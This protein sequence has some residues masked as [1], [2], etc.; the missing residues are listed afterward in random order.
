[1]DDG[2]RIVWIGQPDARRAAL[3]PTSLLAVL[4]GVFMVAAVALM[5]S[6]VMPPTDDD[7]LSQQP[8]N[9]AVLVPFGLFGLL[10]M[11]RP[12]AQ[13]R[14]ARRTGYVVTDRRIAMV[15]VGRL[16]SVLSIPTSDL[17]TINVAERG[18]GSGDLF[19]GTAGDASPHLC[20]SGVPD[21]RGVESAVRDALTARGCAT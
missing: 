12:L 14:T 11:R 18:D 8:P 6:G 19:L 10:M 20:F 17:G 2:E 9:L 21:V 1:L 7:G 4:L 3:A 16:R 15:R 5:V 13:Y